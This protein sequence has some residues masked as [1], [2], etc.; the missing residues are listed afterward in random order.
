MEDVR[1]RFV[2]HQL[3]TRDVPGAKKFYSRLI[4]WNAQPWPT[5]PSYTVCVAGDAPTAGMMGMVPEFPADVPPHWMQYIG[6]RDVDATAEAALLA[7]GFI[8]K[9]PSDMKGAGRYA[10]LAD[11]QGAVFAI[12]DPENARAESKGVPP[13][14]HFS[15]HELAT[16]DNEAAFAFYSNLFGWEA[17]QRMDMGPMGIYLIFGYAGEQKGGMYIKPPDM[18]APSC[19]VPY[20]HVPSVDAAGPI[21][22]AT[23]GKVILAPMDVP[24]GSR[25]AVILDP[26][27]ATFALHSYPDSASGDA[28]PKAPA[29]PKAPA[30]SKMESR[31]KVTSKPKAKAKAKAK[32][33]AKSK[34]KAKLKVKAKAKSAARKSAPKKSKSRARAKS[35][36]KPKGR[37]KVARRKK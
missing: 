27:G 6:T 26:S 33:K 16:T 3:M 29:R 11:P 31:P 13:L 37:N 28:T 36:S 8:V 4:G 2:W 24:G 20:V 14:G 21:V 9:Q 34:R 30:K 12:I 17:M 1:G 5:D 18:P 10:V 22:E 32:Q 25:I 23:G 7:G 35:K 19:W 15:W